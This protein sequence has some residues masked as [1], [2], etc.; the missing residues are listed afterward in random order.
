MKIPAV[1]LLAISQFFP[2]FVVLT[3]ANPQS[4]G[5]HLLK[6]IPLTAAP[7]GEEYFDYFTVDPSAC[8]FYLSDGTEGKVV[9]ADTGVVVGVPSGL[10]RCHVIALVNELS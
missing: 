10:K 8:R 3:A 9:D 7:G 1:T 4:G 6:T 2:L 5:Y